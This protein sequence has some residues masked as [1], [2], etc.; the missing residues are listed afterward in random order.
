MPKIESQNVS[1]AEVVMENKG[2][3]VPME[4][5]PSEMIR[6]AISNKSDLSQV[7]ELLNL[8]KDYEAY[9]AKKAYVKSMAEFKLHAPLV[10]KD[11][12][13]NQYKSKYTSL[14]N[15]VNTV[16]PILSKFG[17]SASWD[18]KQN[19]IIEVT[20]KL[21]HQ[22]GHSETA[23]MSAPADIS[24]AKNAIQ[25]IKSTVTYLKAVTFESICGLASTDANLDD[26]GNAIGVEMIDHKQVNT[27]LDMLADKQI[28]LVKFLAFMKVESIEKMPKSEYQKAFSAIENK[29]KVKK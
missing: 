27:L 1:K 3:V 15:L 18:V 24:G 14:G 25:Q 29:G 8:R 5:T 20:C 26:D 21:T 13:N 10:G 9:D 6:L 4:N 11:K 2:I 28:D 19:G 16:T 7:K 22:L 17:F 12:E 23:S